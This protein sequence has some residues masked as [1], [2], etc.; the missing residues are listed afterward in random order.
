MQP[1]GSG[2]AQ[3]RATV[4]HALAESLVSPVP[5]LPDALLAAAR[6]GGQVLDSE[7]CRQAAMALESLPLR[8]D[9]NLRQQYAQV[10]T[11]RGRRPVALY[12]SL[13]RHERLM[14][15][16]GARRG[17]HLSRAGCRARAGRV[18]RPCQRRI[19]FLGQPVGCG[20]RACWQ[21]EHKDDRTPTPRTA[22]VLARTRGGLVAGDRCNVERRFC[23]VLL[24]GWELASQFSPRGTGRA[25]A[26]AAGCG[27]TPHLDRRGSLHAV[28]A[29]HWPVRRGRSPHLGRRQ[30]NTPDTDAGPLQRLRPL[31]GH[32]PPYGAVG[33]GRA[34]QVAPTGKTRPAKPHEPAN[35]FCAV[36]PGWPV[37]AADGQRSARPRWTRCWPNCS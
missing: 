19:G 3:A 8:G 28:R 17:A 11:P 25:A 35:K 4:Y 23:T 13:Y 34:G 36:L 10:M 16:A 5:D 2:L 31:R 21:P 24:C 15:Q 9:L 18:A 20:S 29:L 30:R 6:T 27:S 26:P 12:E 22:Q 7:A 37:P 14:G 33:H 1:T 32:L